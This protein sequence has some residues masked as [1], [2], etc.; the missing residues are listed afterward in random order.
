MFINRYLGR[1]F[2]TRKGQEESTMD[3][4]S[5]F[6]KKI[7]NGNGNGSVVTAPPN[8]ISVWR[9][10]YEFLRN[11]YPA[12][13]KFQ[14]RTYPSVEHAYQASKTSNETEREQIANADVYNAKKIGRTVALDP[15]FDDN[16][17]EQMEFLVRQKFFDSEEL[18]ESL[19][20]TGDAKLIMQGR[21]TF[22]GGSMVDGTLLGGNHLGNILMKIRRELFS[23][24][25]K[26]ASQKSNQ[27]VKLLDGKVADYLVQPLT[28]LL[29]NIK[30][31]SQNIWDDELIEDTEAAYQN[32]MV[33][34]TNHKDDEDADD[35][36]FSN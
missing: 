14:G 15:E 11:D 5:M 20:E 30:L 10:E 27:L 28:T 4:S 2:K 13:I 19:M 23:V 22:W 9:D 36:G 17:V 35:F 32:L 16:R 29:E 18:A 8:V 26:P 31:G 6:V 21:D 25:G 1:I 12:E 34:L 24:H 3:S 33:I 7:I